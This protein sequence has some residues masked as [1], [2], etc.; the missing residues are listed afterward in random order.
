MDGNKFSH[1]LFTK[2]FSLC[3]RVLS[4]IISLNIYDRRLTFFTNEL[5]ALVRLCLRTGSMLVLQAISNVGTI[6]LVSYLFEHKI[7]FDGL[8]S[9]EDC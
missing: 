6:D 7:M 9:A 8:A 4:V 5:S 1:F 3:W 2:P